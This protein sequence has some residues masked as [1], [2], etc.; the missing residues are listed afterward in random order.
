MLNNGTNPLQPSWINY[1]SKSLKDKKIQPLY[2][3]K[4]P[5]TPDYSKEPGWNVIYYD[6]GC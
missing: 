1:K 4:N 6:T 5:D 2:K 3:P